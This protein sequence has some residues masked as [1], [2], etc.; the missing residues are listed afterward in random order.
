[1]EL[2]TQLKNHLFSGTVIPAHPLALDAE[3]QLDEF[4]QRLLTRYYV[5]SG[6]GG[7][8]VGVHTTQFEIRKPEIN[9]YEK[10]LS[11]AADEVDKI[12]PNR[13]FIKVAG[14]SGP[15]DQAIEEALIA[16]KLGYDIV[17][18]SINGLGS[19]S[20]NG[21][22]DR[23]RE[24]GKHMPL[25]GF[26][27]QPS[28]GGKVLSERFW[29][30]FAEIEGVSA[31]K[32]APFNRYQTIEV[33]RAVCQ[34]SRNDEVAI[35]TG[36]D[37]NILIDLLTTYEIKTSKG[38]IHKDIVGGLLGHWAVWTKKAVDLLHR[39]K[40]IKSQGTLINMELL[41]EN[42][43]ITDSNAALFDTKN[44][45]KGCIAGIHEV[46]RRQGLL[47]GIWCINPRETISEG[48]SDEIDRIYHDYPELTDDLFV[49]K[50]IENWKKEVEISMK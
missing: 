28:V 45:F 48:Q 30:D 39:V 5:A 10:V 20:E 46:L 38:N 12:N 27:L 49:K 43:K 25:F 4:R 24:I 23:A 22:L 1:M 6:S 16:K 3:R 44:N 2:P 18:V 8:A 13:P 47:E 19:W 37:D 15:T 33:V 50:H 17:L 14:V 11:L 41:T 35:Y 42:V 34:S 31:I 26:Y 40:E 9:L 7:I 32:V 29:C 36:N 21:L